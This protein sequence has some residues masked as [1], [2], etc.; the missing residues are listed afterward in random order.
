MERRE[1]DSSVDQIRSI[2]ITGFRGIRRGLIESL[3]DVNILVG[4]NNS[5]K[6]TVGEA[7]ARAACCAAGSRIDPLGRDRIAPWTIPRHE[8]ASDSGLALWYRSDGSQ[9]MRVRV[10]DG[11]GTNFGFSAQPVVGANPTIGGGVVSSTSLREFAAGVTLFSAADANEEMIER[12]VWR[13]LLSTRSDKALAES[14][15]TMFDMPNLERLE[16]PFDAKLTLVFPDHVLSLDSQGEGTRAAVRFL[17]VLSSLRNTLL[18]F[19]HP[20]SHQHPGS[21]ERFAEAVCRQARDQEV[22][23][24]L[25]THS[26]DCVRAFFKGAGSAHS[27][28]ALFHLSLREGELGVRRLQ[29]EG[30]TALE[31]MGTDV[32]FLDLYE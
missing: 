28:A 31:G 25:T 30:V 6:T 7:I 24:L 11:K 4:Q 20:E 13:R 27:E 12:G 23:L 14:L 19:E 8:G 21:L 9:E 26:A 2:E 17:L 18:M 32:R 15:R 3:A 16:F 10:D 22:Q 29:E 1:Y 5:G